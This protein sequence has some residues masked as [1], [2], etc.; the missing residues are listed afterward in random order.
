MLINSGER[1][2]E[3]EYTR[4]QAKVSEEEIDPHKS[5]HFFPIYAG[6]V[7]SD[8]SQNTDPYY[9]AGVTN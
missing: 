5:I 1:G 9:I 6:V 7:P 2:D 8:L 4:L 3:I